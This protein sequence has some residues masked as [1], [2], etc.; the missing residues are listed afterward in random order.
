MRYFALSM[1]MALSLNWARAD[2][3]P[4]PRPATPPA[5]KNAPSAKPP[6]PKADAVIEADIKARLGRSKLAADR[7]EVRVR[8][9]IATFDGRTGVVQHKGA[10]TRMA[11]SA[12]ALAVVNNIKITDE[13]RNRAAAQLKARK[14][15]VK[16]GDPRSEKR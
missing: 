3:S 16:R 11:R 5:A 13:A 10:A 15:E 2:T 9:G 7:F 14:L 6:A 1:I 12:G 8:N 4:G